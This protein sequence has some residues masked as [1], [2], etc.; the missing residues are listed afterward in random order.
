MTKS[1][2]NYNQRNVNM[3]TDANREKELNSDFDSRLRITGYYQHKDSTLLSYPPDNEYIYNNGSQSSVK[4]NGADRAGPYDNHEP[5]KIVN[6]NPNFTNYS[7][8][9]NIYLTRPNLVSTRPGTTVTRP[10]T[11]TKP[12]RDFLANKG[13]DPASRSSQNN[14]QKYKNPSSIETPI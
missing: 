1:D 2:S 7:H 9:P 3:N 11:G 13:P 4:M 12:S 5:S 8:I 14:A 6:F 10:V